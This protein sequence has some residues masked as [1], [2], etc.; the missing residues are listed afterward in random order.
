MVRGENDC[1][2]DSHSAN[3]PN[4]LNIG[5]T[6]SDKWTYACSFK[7][8]NTKELFLEILYFNSK[9]RTIDW[10]FGYWGGTLKRWYDEGLPKTFG[11]SKEVTYGEGVC[12]PGLHWPMLSFAN[13]IALEKDVHNYFNFDEN[14]TTFPFN[15]WIYPK[16]EKKIIKKV[17]NK[18]ELWDS[19]GIKKV[20]FK[21]GSSMPFWLEFPVKNEK[22]WEILKEE[23]LNL[24]TLGNRYMD[25]MEDFL[26]KAKSRSFPLCLFGDPVGFFG[27][28]RF[29]IGEE[30]LFLFYYDKPMLIK[31][32]QNYLCDFWIQIAEEILA[33]ADIDCVFF[34]ED[35]SGKNGS[36]ISPKI[37][38]EFMTPCYKRIINFLRNKGLKH[39]V[40]DTDGNVSELIP[41]FLEV[42]ITGMYPFEVQ[43]KND[44]LK[45]RKKYP[46]L[47]IFGGI[48]KNELAKDK[49][50]IDNELVKVKEMIKLGGYIPYADHL[51]PPNV[52]WENFKYYRNKLKEI[53]F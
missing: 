44:I 40:V 22:D 6:L 1:C 53:I 30:N 45:I 11:L 33:K 32:I 49:L 50:A 19:D 27:S 52:S 15:H 3:Y 34:W 20:I 37:F 9:I 36:L 12:G 35:M 51:I 4:I 26:N 5:S 43:A 14:L 31:N 46:H 24:N 25:S 2:F 48:D 42:G 8:M 29:L 10:E 16:F 13:E 38:R 47:Q 17:N 7:G 39:F 23:R 18:I 41:L 21:D 28:L